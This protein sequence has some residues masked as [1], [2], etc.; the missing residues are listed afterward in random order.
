MSEDVLHASARGSTDIFLCRL[1][2][3]NRMIDE[4]SRQMTFDLIMT[5]ADQSRT[6]EEM[7]ANVVVEK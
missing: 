1:S 4:R 5:Y 2:L 7:F 6:V 3:D